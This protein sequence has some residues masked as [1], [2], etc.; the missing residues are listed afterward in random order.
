MITSLNTQLFLWLFGLTGN[1]QV[2]DWVFIMCAQYLPYFVIALVIVFLF[3]HRH[4]S[5]HRITFASFMQHCTETL[6]VLGTAGSA[7]LL[8]LLIKQAVAAA[9]PFMM[10]RIEPLVAYGGLDS[11]PSGHAAFFMA[12]AV[13]LYL[14]HKRAGIYV[15]CAAIIIGIARIIVGVHFPL[16]IFV[17]WGMGAVLALLIYRFSL[18]IHAYFADERI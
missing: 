15:L 16:D 18:G 2:L 6:L 17:G 4:N 3:T 13:A 14:F 5:G 11:F 1:S 12:L 9:R 7:W 10:L 8:S